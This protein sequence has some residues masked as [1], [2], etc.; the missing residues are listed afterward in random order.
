[1]TILFAELEDV[2]P[3]EPNIPGLSAYMMKVK[4]VNLAENYNA[5]KKG[6][7]EFDDLANTIA[8][9]FSGVLDNHAGYHKLSVETLEE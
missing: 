5:P 8:K 3:T 6:S 9:S 4:I 7:R 1:M 2:V